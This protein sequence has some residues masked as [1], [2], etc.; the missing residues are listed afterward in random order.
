LEYASVLAWPA[1]VT[2]REQW[3]LQRDYTVA[4]GL[5]AWGGI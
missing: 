3:E 4:L 1:L 2:E 5:A